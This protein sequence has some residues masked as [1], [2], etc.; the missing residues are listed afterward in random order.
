MFF[1][2]PIFG[3]CFLSCLALFAF[4]VVG[5]DD[6]D[7]A[8]EYRVMFEELKQQTGHVDALLASID[9]EAKAREVIPELKESLKKAR[10]TGSRISEFEK[11]TTRSATGL[12]NAIRRFRE[13]RKIRYRAELRRLA[14][15]PEVEELLVPVLKSGG[16]DKPPQIQ[17]PPEI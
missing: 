10:D 15:M 12:K 5:C 8:A 3:R 2:S 9:G 16:E 14:R 6:P 11:I 4:G 17:G 7:P 13:E 1:P